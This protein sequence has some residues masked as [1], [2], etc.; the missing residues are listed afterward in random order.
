MK[1]VAGKGFRIDNPIDEVEDHKCNG[2]YFPGY[3]VNLS[4]L[5]FPV[6][7]RTL[8]P[9][10]APGVTRQGRVIGYVYLKEYRHAEHAV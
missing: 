9:A 4:R 2:E 7:W 10:G 1:T 6:V 3:F 5:T 8:R